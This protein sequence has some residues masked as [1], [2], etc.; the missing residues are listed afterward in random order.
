[1]LINPDRIDRNSI[2]LFV[3]V[4]IPNPRCIVVRWLFVGLRSSN[5]A[6]QRDYFG[7]SERGLTSQFDFPSIDQ[8]IDRTTVICSH[9]FEKKSAIDRDE[10][11]LCDLLG[12][13]FVDPTF[14]NKRIK[15]R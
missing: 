15:R 12:R 3:F 4:G 13:L 7:F 14:A 6:E 5:I 8:L 2:K 11:G 9:R 1:M 10:V